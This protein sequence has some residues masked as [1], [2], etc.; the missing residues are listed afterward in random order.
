MDIVD[1]QHVP[2]NL[3][4]ETLLETLLI[5]KINYCGTSIVIV[6]T[7]LNATTLEKNRKEKVLLSHCYLSVMFDI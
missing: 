4:T 2:N 6:S 1:A 3:L 7:V 5:L